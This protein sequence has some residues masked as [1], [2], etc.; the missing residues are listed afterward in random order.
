MAKIHLQILRELSGVRGTVSTAILLTELDCMSLPDM[1]LVRAVKF[2]NSLANL[3]P[4]HLY[5]RIALFACHAAVTSSVRN[6]AWYMFKSIRDLGYDMT[7]RIDSMD[8]L[9]LS[10]VLQLLHRRSEVVWHALDYCPRTCPSAKARL[11]TYQAWFARLPGKSAAAILSL[12]LSVRCLQRFLRFRMGCHGLPRDTGSWTHTPRTARTCQL[13]SLHS[14]GDEKHLVFECPA[15]HCLRDT[16]QHLFVGDPT[17][18]QFLWQHDLVGVA[19]F[20][21]ACLELVYAAGPS[22]GGQ[23]SDQP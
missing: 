21:D 10:R 7:I 4:S 17:M 6:W 11:C 20:I 22:S 1:W 3:P 9:D 19:K 13:C 8:T 15:L 12:P 23:A 14:L 16:Y 18:R 5:R 2:W